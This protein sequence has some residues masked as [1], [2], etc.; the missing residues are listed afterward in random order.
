MISCAI[1]IIIITVVTSIAHH[2]RCHVVTNNATQHLL[3]R[4]Y[5]HWVPA[6]SVTD[7]LTRPAHAR[8][9]RCIHGATGPSVVSAQ[10]EKLLGVVDLR[11]AHAQPAPDYTKRPFVFHLRTAEQHEYLLQARCRRASRLVLVSSVSDTRSSG[12][13]SAVQLIVPR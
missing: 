8:T 9:T 4:R 11:G 12:G 7:W 10:S 2:H 1:V 6:R 13:S 3:R 5:R